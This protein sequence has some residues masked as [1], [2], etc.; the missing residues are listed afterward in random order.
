MFFVMTLAFTVSE[1]GSPWKILSRG[2]PDVLWSLGDGMMVMEVVDGKG[3][4]R[5]SEGRRVV[6][7]M[8]KDMMKVERSHEFRNPY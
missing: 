6:S 3:E 1:I 4:L 2:T 7:W 5:V 8:S